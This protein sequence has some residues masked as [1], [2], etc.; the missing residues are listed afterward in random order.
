M[1][2]FAVIPIEGSDKLQLGYALLKEHWGNGYASESVKGGIE[3]AFGHLN[4]PEI[5]GITYP[6]N[7]PSQKVLLKNGFVLNNTFK[8]GNNELHYYLLL[9][10]KK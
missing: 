3:Y 7:I 6:A 5:A 10:E 1:G 9:R 2:S 4:L 8:E